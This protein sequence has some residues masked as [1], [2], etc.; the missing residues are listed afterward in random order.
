M[1]DVLRFLCSY[2]DIAA[3]GK[4]MGDLIYF[5][6]FNL[7]FSHKK[8]QNLKDSLKLLTSSFCGRSSWFLQEM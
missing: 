7:L 3:N 5:L 1:V 6:T 8:L 2:F 4:P